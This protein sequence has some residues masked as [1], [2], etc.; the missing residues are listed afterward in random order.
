MFP[1]PL[2]DQDRARLLALTELV[3]QEFTASDWQVLAAKTGTTDIVDGQPPT[4]LAVTEA[5]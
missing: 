2:S 4:V 5:A 1:S 3:I